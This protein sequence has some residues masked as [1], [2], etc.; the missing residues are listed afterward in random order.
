MYAAIA[1][2]LWTVA[3]AERLKVASQILEIS[4]WGPFSCDS[5]AGTLKSDLS[6]FSSWATCKV[7]LFEQVTLLCLVFMSENWGPRYLLNE[8]VVRIKWVHAWKGPATY[9]LLNK[10]SPPSLHCAR[11]PFCDSENCPLVAL[12][13]KKGLFGVKS[14]AIFVPRTQASQL[15]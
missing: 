10:H 3:R 4:Q 2:D 7:C 8:R 5:T 15:F 6:S 9:F 13:Y 11:R 12:F 14:P 1:I